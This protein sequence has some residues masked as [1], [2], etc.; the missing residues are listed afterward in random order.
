MG[1]S[2]QI[3]RCSDAGTTVE[4]RTFRWH[5]IEDAPEG[6]IQIVR[7]KEGAIRIQIIPKRHR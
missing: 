1:Q 2:K 6:G 5:I 3:V 7:G 4:N